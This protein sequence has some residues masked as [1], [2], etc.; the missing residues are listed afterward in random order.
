MVPFLML[1][2][3]IISIVIGLLW[4]KQVV[5]FKSN[6]ETITTEKRNVDKFIEKVREAAF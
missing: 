3:G 5:E 6:T 4:R 1:I 2:L